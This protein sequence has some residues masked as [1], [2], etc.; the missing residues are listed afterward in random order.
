MPGTFR[1]A[2]ATLRGRGGAAARPG[3][4][5]RADWRAIVARADGAFAAAPAPV[6]VPPA[7]RRF[8]DRLVPFVGVALGLTLVGQAVALLG[9]PGASR[10][11]DASVETASV[12]GPPAAVRLAAPPARRAAPPVSLGIARIGVRSS[13][14]RLGVRRDGTIETPENYGQAGWY[15][16]GA[17]P[18]EPGPAVIVGHVDSTDG[19]A[20]FFRLR[21]LARGDRVE[22]RRTDGTVVTY[23]V[24]AVRT[25]PKSRFPTKDVY[26]ATRGSTLR[27]VTC[28][29]SFDTK[30]RSYRDNVVVYADLVAP[31]PAGGNR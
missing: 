22:V 2:V 21:E 19:P 15:R 30:S 25:Y 29:G 6:P 12:A 24:T 14:A 17:R 31:R 10:P 13:L 27:L 11:A 5:T 1:R 3:D 26:G 4:P 9:P 16:A 23:A 7:S 8:S 28:G 18:G 20:V